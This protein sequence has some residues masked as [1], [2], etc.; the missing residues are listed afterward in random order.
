MKNQFCTDLYTKVGK[1]IQVTG[2][3]IHVFYALKM[4]KKYPYSHFPLTLL[5]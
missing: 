4:G 1:H 2:T 3:T 5:M